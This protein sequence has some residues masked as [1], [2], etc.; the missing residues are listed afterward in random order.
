M[1]THAYLLSQGWSG[2]GNPLNANRRPGP[3]GGLGLTKPILIARKKN[4]H[5]LGRK[6][7]HDHTNQWWL[8]GF[9]AALKCVGDD[10]SA[11]PQSDRS[12]SAASGSSELY[13]FFVKGESLEG[14]IDRIEAK[15]S[16]T[17]K[18]CVGVPTDS[19]KGGSKRKRKQCDEKDANEERD[20][21]VL[22]EK[23][24][25]KCR[26]DQRDCREGGEVED[27]RLAVETKEE[28]RRKRRE[29]ERKEKE[30]ANLE[31]DSADARVDKRECK[32]RKQL[33][34]ADSDSLSPA[35]K[36]E[37][38]GPAEEHEV[39]DQKERKKQRKLEKEQ[40]QAQALKHK[41]RKPKRREKSR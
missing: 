10:G 7:T 12:G 30:T 13:R 41:E 18:G 21:K 32:K 34:N 5:G 11:T 15:E 4:N 40:N 9:E 3:H 27:E 16:G 20:K 14:T 33:D 39:S 25:K 31:E 8:R 23:R 1:D 2:P 35:E 24:R 19:R 36:K 17:V 6:T 26:L 37:E 38:T 29:K 22:K 28:K